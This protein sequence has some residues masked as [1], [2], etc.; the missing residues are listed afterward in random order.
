[1]GPFTHTAHSAYIW[2]IFLPVALQK[3]PIFYFI[4][5]KI[6]SP[7]LGILFYGNSKMLTP[8]SMC[9]CKLAPWV[10]MVTNRTNKFFRQIKI[11]AP[12]RYVM[13][14]K[15][16]KKRSNL[17]QLPI[18]SSDQDSNSIAWY[19]FHFDCFPV[20][21]NWPNY[22]SFLIL[23][24][25]ALAIWDQLA[26]MRHWKKLMIISSIFLSLI[27]HP[28]WAKFPDVVFHCRPHSI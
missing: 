3:N 19:D 4:F 24:D 23:L 22:C 28:N 12:Y 2:W 17:H 5:E 7:G 9:K 26:I 25:L 1:M 10:A 16:H 20:K 11:A 8:F 21:L 15:V 27:R 13:H 18:L 6:M 14:K